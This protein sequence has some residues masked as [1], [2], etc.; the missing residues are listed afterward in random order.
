MRLVDDEASDAASAVQAVQ[1]AAEGRRLRE[2]LWSHVQQA[3][4]ALTA[5]GVE[6]TAEKTE[7]AVCRQTLA[8]VLKK[9][10]T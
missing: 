10:S 8:G 2:S 7:T 5:G 1:G 4:A 9:A 6:A 3:Q